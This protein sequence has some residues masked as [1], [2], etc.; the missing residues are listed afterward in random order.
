MN[1][2]VLFF[3]VGLLMHTSIVS[4]QPASMDKN[5]EGI[6]PIFEAKADSL[7]KVGYTPWNNATFLATI[8][9]NT[10]PLSIQE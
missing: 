4:E 7:S 6:F 8:P 9:F 5:R 10:E 1:K 2:P 3:T